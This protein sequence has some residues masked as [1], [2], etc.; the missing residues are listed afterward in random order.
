MAYEGTMKMP[1]R[2]FSAVFQGTAVLA[3]ALSL[4]VVSL[5]F[6]WLLPSPIL[7]MGS[8]VVTS[9]HLHAGQW[10]DYKYHYCKDKDIAAETHYSFVDEIVYS[11]PGMMVTRLDVGCHDA[12]E[13][14][15]VPNIPP[16]R[17]RLEMMRV[18]QPTPLR[19]LE[20]RAVSGYFTIDP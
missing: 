2:V 4:V 5:A 8:L 9:E 15:S 10:L 16:G 6:A 19:R 7:Q 11:T 12:Y 13:G 3:A 1:S 17:Y 18:Y 14:L 20:V